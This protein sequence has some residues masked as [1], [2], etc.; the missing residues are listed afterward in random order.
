MATDTETVGVALGDDYRYGFSMPENYA[1]KS[2][3]DG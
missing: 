3:R 2:R 1:F